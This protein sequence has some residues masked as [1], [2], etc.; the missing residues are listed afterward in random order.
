MWVQGKVYDSKTNNGLPSSVELTDVNTRKL[1]SKVQTDENGNYLT[2]LPVGKNYAFNVNRKGYL[3]FSEHYDLS[4]GKY[5][6][7][8]QADIPLQPIVAG[9][10]IVLK[11]IFF[12]TK[13]TALNPASQAELDKVVQLLTDNPSLKILITG[14][15]DNIGKPQDN[16]TL[17]NGRALAVTSYLLSTRLV[18]KERLQYKGLGS[19]KPIADNSTEEGRSQNRRTELSVISNDIVK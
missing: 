7:I 2:T 8:F 6:S 1:I 5:D 12:D 13:Q 16:I 4:T 18:A 10:S 9:N 17:S 11:N 14:H 3:F 15:T 19:S